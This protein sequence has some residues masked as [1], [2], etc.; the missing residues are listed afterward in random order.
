MSTITPELQGT[1]ASHPEWR[2]ICHYYGY[3]SRV[4]VCGTATRRAGRGHSEKYCNSRGHS[5]C[6]VC[7]A[8]L[9]NETS[10]G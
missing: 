5:I 4:S 7:T 1:N 8:M 9:E 6:V 2:R 3:E 10:S